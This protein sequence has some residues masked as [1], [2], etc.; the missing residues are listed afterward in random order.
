MRVLLKPS[1]ATAAALPLVAALAVVSAARHAEDTAPEVVSAGGDSSPKYRVDPW[2]PKPLPNNWILGQVAGVS[3]DERDHVW[4]VQRPG[5][6]TVEEAGAAQKPPIALCCVAA[7]PVLEFDADGNVVRGWGGPGAGYDWFQSEHGILA[8]GQGHV[9]VAGNGERDNHVLKF[10]RDGKFILQIGK[11]GRHGGSNDTASL[12]AP[13]GLEFD[14]AA[15]ELYVADGYRNRRVIVFDATTGAYKRHWGAYGAK[16]DDGA[17]AAYDPKAAPARQFRGPVHAV[18][19]STDG[20]VYVADRLADR[21]QVFRKNGEF[22]KEALIR[23]E[24]LAMGSVWDL[25]FSRDPEQ[26]WLLVADG[27]NRVVWILDRQSLNIV[28]R[29]GSGGR[30][31]GQ[32]GWVHNL[33]IDSRGNVYTS[34]VET[35]KRVQ[36][37]V[38]DLAGR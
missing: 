6:L 25:A 22:V 12:G 23:P 4:I 10:T 34:E 20:Y 27:S 24:T 37:F 32:F 7:P 9:W 16:P 8:D 14:A 11:S 2:W 18:R 28:D 21:I 26:Q 1:V 17:L 33:A 35:G 19:I 13:A 15:N 36:R 38:L 29:F 3:V 5:S 31:A 30:N